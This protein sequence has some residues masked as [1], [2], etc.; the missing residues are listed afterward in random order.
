MNAPERR[1]LQ[2]SDLARLHFVSDPQISPDGLQIAFV[3]ETLDL[4]ANEVRSRIWIVDVD[5][6]GIPRPLTAGEKQDGEPRWSPNGQMLAFVSNRGGSRQI[7]LLSPGE[8]EPRQITDHPVGAHEPVWSPDGSRLAFLALG[9]DRAGEPVTPEEKDERK[10]LIRVREHR[11]KLDGRG[12]FGAMREHVW[13]VLVAGGP[14]EQ[15]TDGPYDDA[16]PAWSPDGTLLAFVSDRSVKRDRRY[17]GGA[18]HL[19]DVATRDVRRL[20]AEDGRAAHPSWSP[21][22]RWIAYVGSELADDAS[23]SQTHLWIVNVDGKSARRLTDGLD[24]SV[25]QRPGGYLTPSP[26]AWTR[27]GAVLLYLVSD[28]PATHFYRLSE[29]ERVALTGGRQVVHSFSVD[30]AARRAALLVGDALTPPEIWLWEGV[31][32]GDQAAE[33]G[34]P[35]RLVTPLL[36]GQTETTDESTAP[37][38]PT[39]PTLRQITALNDALLSEVVL[40]APEDLKVD[41]PDGTVV[42]GWLLR[43]TVPVRGRLPL[44]LSVHGGPHNYFGHTFSFDHQLLAASGIAVL[45]ANPR[46]SGGYTEAFARAVCEDWGGEDFADLMAL[47]DH[48]IER[49]DPPIDR[50][51]L[52]ITGSSYGGF[53]TCWAITQTDRFAAAVAGACISNLISFFGTSDIGASWGEREFGGTPHERLSWYLERSPLSH[54]ER[55]KT[56]LLLYHG[57]ADLRC[58]IEQSEQ[59]FTALNRLGKVVELLRVPGESHA[60]LNGS[61]AHRIEVRRAILDWF[62]SYL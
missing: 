14:A 19:V 30:R 11:H 54:V 12:F 27:E 7:W 38:E 51:R 55:V 57:E 17:G 46:G 48:A 13:V 41:R 42:E 22:G 35:G 3:V 60:V 50:S 34:L 10:R 53:M 5:G 25:G 59:M 6:D 37:E 61:P 1:P 45:Y 43:P 29:I 56:P 47:L 28:G 20:T 18:V 24:R 52:G 26:P 9:P 39:T 49:A 62:R 4:E 15:V 21:G 33:L 36:T 40:S 32:L 23:P 44:I 2:L 31:D 16:S 8:A 58:P